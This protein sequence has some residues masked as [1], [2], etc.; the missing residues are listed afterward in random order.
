MTPREVEEYRAL[1][2]TIRDRGTV[3]VWLFFTTMAAWAA[4]TI[5]TG[6]LAA[7]PV[8]TLLPLLLLASG[9]ETVFNVYTGIERI[10][11]YLQVFHAPG[12]MERDWE[13]IVMAYGAA[14][15]GAGSDPLFSSYF[16]LATVLNFVPVLLAEP[17]RLEV[18]VV[19]AVHLV[20]VGRV[21]AAR[22]ASGRQ[23]A[24]DLERFERLKRDTH[25]ANEQEA[26][27]QK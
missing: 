9:F 17:V 3:R 8:A 19:G 11:R 18:S 25:D 21:I 23:R 5:A 2:A 16:F 20:F 10:G 26:A 13:R 27:R 4:A 15:P 14:Y 12:E 24:L 7:L 6:A 1:R 22:R